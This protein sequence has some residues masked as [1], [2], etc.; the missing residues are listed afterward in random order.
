[1]LAQLD[2]MDILPS[3]LSKL[4]TVKGFVKAC[5]KLPVQVMKDVVEVSHKEEFSDNGELFHGLKIIITDG[6]K[7]SLP[8]SDDVISKYEK[9]DGHYP[10][11]LAVGFYELSTRTFE[12]FKTAH[13]DTPERSVAYEHMKENQCP[14]LYLND[15]GY[16]GMAFIAVTTEL[17]HEILMPLKMSSLVRKMRVSKAKSAIFEVKLNKTHLKNYPEHQHLLGQVLTIRLLRTRGTTK[18][19]SQILVTTLLDEK[20]FA[21]RKLIELYR[22]RYL[23]EVA[24]RHLKVNLRL[25]SI[26]KRKLS[27]IEKCLY[28]AV[29]LYNIAAT[30]R[31]RIKSPSIM[32]EKHGTKTYCFSLCLSRSTLFCLAAIK[33]TRGTKQKIIKCLKTIRNCWFIHKPWRS[34][35]RICNTPPSKFSV[36]KGAN[37][38]REI[39]NAKFLRK[40]YEVLGVQY[41]HLEPKKMA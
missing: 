7:V 15:A 14:T 5:D 26:N 23:V 28:A 25:E 9:A 6:T 10:Q 27:R 29:S 19:K 36:Q 33:A 24:F 31:N 41:G 37:K 30:V 40:E 12:D 32:P 39:T 18:L 35:P 3:S 21:W 8:N 11:C 22:Q 1:V 16:N 38:E 4:P 13:K 2:E 34:E 20:K 17:G